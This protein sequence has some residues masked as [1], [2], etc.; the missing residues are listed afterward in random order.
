MQKELLKEIP[1]ERFS[2]N[3]WGLAPGVTVTLHAT[4][5]GRKIPNV[6]ALIDTGSEIT[7]I[8][9]QNVSINPSELD[10]LPDVK[11]YLI[12]I[13]L[14][15]EEYLVTCGLQNHPYQ[16]SEQALLGMNVLENWLTKL[17]GKKHLLSVTHLENGKDFDTISRRVEVPP[18]GPDRMTW[19]NISL[20]QFI[21][22]LTGLGLGLASILGG[23]VLFFKGISG[24]INWII[25]AENFNSQLVNAS[26]GAILF[27]AGII[28]IW[29]TRFD[30]L[31]TYRKQHQL[32]SS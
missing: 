31:A 12:G 17:H 4:A 25:K 23:I 9:P 10:Q 32:P 26:P 27:V 29:I 14:E 21:Y 20:Y 18:S 6:K 15:G 3:Q 19:K 8:Y 30:I 24:S 11:E 28:I 5:S 2:Q 22:S 16:G 13:E 7:W 1:Y